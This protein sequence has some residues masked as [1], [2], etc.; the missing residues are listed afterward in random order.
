MPRALRNVL[1]MNSPAG[2]M[3]LSVGDDRRFGLVASED[4]RA[5][6]LFTF[7][8]LNSPVALMSLR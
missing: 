6:L 8:D 2:N 1:Y 7:V 3:I 4:A 5:W